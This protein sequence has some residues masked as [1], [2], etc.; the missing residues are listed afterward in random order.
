MSSLVCIVHC[1]NSEKFLK[2]CLDSILSQKTKHQFQVLIID[3][4]STDNTKKIAY[5][6]VND[7][8]VHFFSTKKNTG[9]GKQALLEL[10]EE[11][12]SFFN[13][14]YVY[15]IDSDDFII[16]S[17]KFEKQISF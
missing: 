6:Y 17:S 11:I 1:Y 7:I 8:N 9:L 10:E 4:C 16:D 14:D 12:K 13:T 15:R 3:D 5:K 2:E